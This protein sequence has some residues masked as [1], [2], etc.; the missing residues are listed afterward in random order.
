MKRK[1][2][3]KWFIIFTI[4]LI[5][6]TIF[7][8][9]IN[10]KSYAINSDN[11]IDP[12]T[13]TYVDGLGRTGTTN[14]NK[15][16]KKRYV[17]IFYWTWHLELN[18]A[19]PFNINEITTA[20]PDAKNNYN[21][22]IWQQYKTSGYY[23]WNQPIYGYYMEDDDYVLRKQAELLADAGVDFVVFDCTNGSFT[24][25][26]AYENLLKVW[27]EASKDGVAVPKI[28]F[29]LSFSYNEDSSGTSFMN[30]YNNLYNPSS[31]NYQ[32]YHELFFN[33]NGKPLI[34]M[35]DY[36]KANTEIKNLLT[37]F[38]VR[39]NYP[40]YF[41]SG[42]QPNG[43]WGWLSTY[44]QAYYKKA[45]GEYE[46]M[47]VGVSMNANYTTNKLSAMN[48]V[49]VMGRSYAKGN[50]SY[51]YKYRNQ[52]INVGSSI[53]GSTA[54]YANTSLYGRNFQQQWDYALSID[55]EIVFV[56]GWNEWIALRFEN[57][58]GT[59]NAF[60]DQFN[61][62]YSRDIEPSNSELM[63][64]YYYQ[65]VDNIRR[66]KGATTQVSQNTPVTIKKLSDWNNEAIISYNHYVGGKIRDSVGFGTTS[67][68][69][70]YNPTFRND[71]KK[72]K[73]SYDNS[74]VYFYV[75]TVNK[76]T[77]ETDDR[78]MRLLIDTTDSINSTSTENWEEFEYI[79]NRNNIV[80][81][82]L[83]LERSTGGWNFETIGNIEYVVNDNILQLRIP[84]SYLGLTNKDIS[85]NFKWCDN[86][87]D[88]GLSSGNIMTI[89][90]DGDS[91][92]GGRFAFHFSG[93]ADYKVPTID[94][95]E[96]V[97]FDSSLE[98][99]ENNK[100]INYLSSNFTVSEFLEKV[101]VNRFSVTVGVYD[102]DGEQKGNNDI[103]ATGDK[104]IIYKNNE[105]YDE[106]LL[107][108][109]GDINGDG[110]ITVTDVS[111]LFQYYRKKITMND[112]YV[113]SGNLVCSS[114]I[115]LT[116]V[117]K[118]FQYVR[119]TIDNLR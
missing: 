71:I 87:L 93:T 63:D 76:L 91:A 79:V 101:V 113:V 114:E 60:P 9:N 50:Y 54:K 103:I 38:E 34:L 95:D 89:Y 47:S 65:L 83:T 56:T 30:I 77:P 68:I 92:P 14:V 111:K 116:D 23:W 104:L 105:K 69:T 6:I 59:T 26:S 90:I 1:S 102:K 51:T 70:Y 119:G 115:R 19:G 35:A 52:T 32:K 40:G 4:I 109:L 37:G 58:L 15:S 49:N 62:E 28:A 25:K 75:E 21:H 100:Y 55:P 43:Y 67:P 7:L 66:Y 94:S 13:W 5:S 82:Q 57:W 118:L 2:F 84:R 17:G 39:K 97:S 110:Q 36:E 18:G 106:Y 73:V 12:S 3:K 48:G 74:Y 81:G 44:P 8:F 22:P 96:L 88:N 24:W 98:I 27:L 29:M 117:A 80:N 11:V 72:A 85:F 53:T 64:Y 99:D 78:W 107:S 112:I 45:N 20:Y 31:S 108:V 61:N 46:Q 86:N 41:A 33:Y 16:D 42:V 10:K